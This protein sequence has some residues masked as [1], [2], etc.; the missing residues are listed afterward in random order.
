MSRQQLENMFVSTSTTTLITTPPSSLRTRPRR[1]PFPRYACT[2]AL[3]PTP[4]SEAKPI[5]TL[6][7]KKKSISKAKP[8]HTLKA[9]PKSVP[10]LINI[11][12]LETI[13]MVKKP[14]SLAENT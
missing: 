7:A 1:A 12:A 11:D 8:K 6:Q 10:M 5:S 14:R 2:F 3:T 13:E 9:K 4:A